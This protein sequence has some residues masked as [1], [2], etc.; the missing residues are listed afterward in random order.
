METQYYTPPPHYQE[1]H[2]AAPESSDFIPLFGSQS[3]IIAG[4]VPLV[5]IDNISISESVTKTPIYTLGMLESLAFEQQN[6]IV[7]ISGTIVQNARM[8]FADTEFYPKNP[9]E[10]M[11]YLN[12]T[13]DIELVMLNAGDPNDP[14]TTPVFTAKGCQRVGSNISVPNGKII[15]SFT[16]IGAYLVRDFSALEN[17]YVRETVES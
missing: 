12:S 3:K 15:D 1:S 6:V 5:G 11:K 13:F 10:M 14:E 4:G 16:V 17:F 2:K 9:A 8:S 7:N